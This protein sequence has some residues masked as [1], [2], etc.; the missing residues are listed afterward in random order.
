MKYLHVAD[1][2]DLYVDPGVS[3]YEDPK[4]IGFR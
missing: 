4:N 3:W 2:E 1:F